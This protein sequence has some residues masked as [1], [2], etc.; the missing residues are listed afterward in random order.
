M[1]VW[2]LIGIP[3]NYNAQDHKALIDT[4]YNI[5]TIT[6]QPLI[7]L[8]MSLN[9]PS[10][11]SSTPLRGRMSKVLGVSALLMAMSCEG[12]CK[13]EPTIIVPDPIPSTSASVAPSASAAL[14]AR[15]TATAKRA[16]VNKCLVKGNIT[17]D[18][19]R[20][21]HVGGCPDYANTKTNRKGERCFDSEAEAIKAGWV[22][23][24]NCR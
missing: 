3:R 9:T 6:N 21:Y 10:S 20:L 23:S 24:S 12:S 13:E 18:G 11:E 16:Q 19:R 8:S 4:V 7:P 22:K 15:A 5:G 2:G 14:S 1:K 17:D